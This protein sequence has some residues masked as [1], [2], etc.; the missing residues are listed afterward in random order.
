MITGKRRLGDEKRF[1]GAVLARL[2]Q[3]GIECGHG[4]AE[5]VEERKPYER[6]GEVTSSGGQGALQLRAIHKTR[7]VKERRH[8]EKLFD[9]LRH[10]SQ[11]IA[12]RDQ[13]VAPEEC[14]NFA[15]R[16]H[17]VHRAPPAVAPGRRMW[18]IAASRVA[19][20][21]ETRR[22]ERGIARNHFSVVE[23]DDTVGNLL[24]LGERVRGKEQRGSAPAHDVVLQ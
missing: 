17:R 14:G 16:A 8:A 12:A 15:E 1:E 3:A 11:A 7:K 4:D 13:E 24:D 9:G 21:V 2:F 5:I 6:E 20:P 19:V 22:P 10:E 18:P 23:E